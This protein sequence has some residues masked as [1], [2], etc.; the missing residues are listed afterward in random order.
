[1]ATSLLKVIRI[2]KSKF[3]HVLTLDTEGL[4]FCALR[5]I[6]PINNY[7]PVRNLL[8]YGKKVRSIFHF[9]VSD[10]LKNILK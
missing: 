8:Q 4:L 5:D 7:C 9:M 6:F 3:I 1:M 10:I 2:Y